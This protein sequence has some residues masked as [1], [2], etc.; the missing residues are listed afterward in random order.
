MS[1]VLGFFSIVSIAIGHIPSLGLVDG[2]D[3]MIRDFRHS[4]QRLAFPDKR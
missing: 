1:I 2:V 4:W 3:R